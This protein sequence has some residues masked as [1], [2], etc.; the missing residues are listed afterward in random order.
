MKLHLILAL[1]ISYYL[2]NPIFGKENNQA[3]VVNILATDNGVGMSRDMRILETE[4]VEM[5][6]QVNLISTAPHSKGYPQEIPKAEYNIFIEHTY[7]SLFKYAKKNYFIPNPEWYLSHWTILSGIDLVLCRTKEVQRIFNIFNVKTHYIA[8]TSLDRFNPAIEKDF[9]KILH[10]KGKSIAKGTSTIIDL[11]KTCYYFPTLDLVGHDFV[12]PV[13]ANIH[14]YSN[15]LTEKAL[16]NLTNQ[17][18]IHLCPSETEGFGHYIMEAMSASAVVVTTDAPPMNEFIKDKR[19]LVQYHK[20]SRTNLATCYY[21][22]P[23]EL[24][25]TITTL[26]DLPDEELQK[27]GELNRANYLYFQNFFKTEMKIL[28]KR[29]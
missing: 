10:L 15:Y 20:K 5:G 11:W 7:S 9:G 13:C 19:C 29:N 6:Y 16:L 1:L 26:L 2:S 22:D 17:C 25:L 4:L 12:G 21:V 3:P 18:G 23:L 27:I 28:F 24:Q 14:Y 8:F